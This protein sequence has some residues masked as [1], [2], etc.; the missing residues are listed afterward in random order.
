MTCGNTSI[1]MEN[2][3]V[4]NLSGTFQQYPDDVVFNASQYGERPQWHQVYKTLTFC[5][6]SIAMPLVFTIGIAG[7]IANL[8][9]FGKKSFRRGLNHIEKS[10]LYGLIVLSASDLGFCLTGFPIGFLSIVEEKGIFGLISFAYRL[11]RGP[12]LNIFLFTSTWLIVIISIE[13]YLAV[14]HP[15]QARLAI[16]PRRSTL[17]H[18]TVMAVAILLNVPLFLTYT[19]RSVPCSGSCSCYYFEP[20]ALVLRYTGF[21]HAHTIVWAIFG[22]FLPFV[23][24][25]FCNARILAVVGHADSL[26]S[27]QNQ[28]KTFSRVTITLVVMIFMYLMLVTPSMVLAFV[29][30]YVG[31]LSDDQLVHFR[32]AL[33]ITNF[34]QSVKFSTNF[35][36]YCVINKQ[37]RE[38]AASNVNCKTTT[39]RTMTPEFSNSSNKRYQI[40]GVHS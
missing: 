32:F 25:S 2:A 36:L 28:S 21:L 31:Q 7:N 35:L 17:G 11:Y 9:V 5:V 38:T 26:A 39:S 14:C 37:F 29:R 10:A 6:T 8:F 12:I 19:I 18:V 24:L 4:L 1:G 20:T 13:R 15:F 16:R 3:T 30:H 23:L 34:C 40:V 33:T 27:D 22:T